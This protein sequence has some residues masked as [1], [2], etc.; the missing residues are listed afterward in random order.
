[1]HA[2]KRVPACGLQGVPSKAPQA[3]AQQVTEGRHPYN[4]KADLLVLDVS[5]LKYQG[6]HPMVSTYREPH[7][8]VVMVTVPCGA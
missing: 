3:D 4:I 5:S 2:P 6:N 7:A 8:M 1:M